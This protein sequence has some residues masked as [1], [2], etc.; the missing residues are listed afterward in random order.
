MPQPSDH[1]GAL[2]EIADSVLRE[3]RFQNFVAQ[4]HSR[5][6]LRQLRTP[7]DQ[8]PAYSAGLDED[9]V[10]A[11][12]TLLYVGL[13]LKLESTP[14]SGDG[15]LTQ[16]AEI[17]EYVY[18]RGADDDPE[19]VSQLFTA[20][21]AYYMAGHF[22]RAFVLVRDLE[23]ESPLPRFLRPLRHLLL[24]QHRLLRR[25]VLDQ[26][27][28]GEY[29]DDGIA[30]AVAAGELDED[31]ALCRILEAT[32]FRALSHYLEYARTG[33]RPL[34]EAAEAFLSGGAEVATDHR[35]AD[36]WWY[37]SCV[38][39]MLRTFDRHSLWS[40]L[41]PY[42][43]QP[44]TADLTRQYVRANLRLPVPLT[45]LWPSQVTAVPRLFAPGL[46]NV[47][48]RMPTSA[49]KTKIAELAILA[50]LAQGFPAADMKCVYVAPF[51]SLA[52]EVEQTLRLALRPLGVRV[53]ELYGGFEFTAADRLL[54]ESTQVLV[55][56]PEKLDAF[57]R[58]TPELAGRLRLVIVD[59]GHI[60]SPPNLRSLHEARGLK[61]EVFLQRLVT[62]CQRSGARIV[63]LSAVMP[64]A[65]QFAEWITGGQDG[66]VT[67]DWRPSRLLLG[68]AVWDGR[69]VD[70]EYTHADRTPL[71]HKCF[72]RG[73]VPSRPPEAVP[74]RGRKHPLPRDDDEAIALAALELARHKLTMV[75]VAQRR[76]TEPLGRT[77]LKCIAARRAIAEHA[78][79]SYGL[80]VAAEHRAAIDRC[81]SLI[82]EHMGEDSNH[83][84]FLG[85][86]FVIHHSGLPQPV[87]IAIERLVRAGAVRLVVATTTL[88]QGVNFPI[89]TV[90]V[91]SLDQGHG[92]PVSAM[93]FWNICG[94]AGRGM[95]ENEG[96]VL[97]FAKQCF[98]EW[99]A[100]KCKS[101]AK[102]ARQPAHW[103]R[104]KWQEWCGEQRAAREAYITQYG[105]YQVQSGLLHLL[106]QV[107]DLWTA[108]HGDLDLAAFCEALAN[109]TLD[110]FAP[111]EAL[112]LDSV[113]S[114]LDGLLIAITE[115][116]EAD[117]ITPDTFQSLLTRSLVHLQLATPADRAFVNE[118]FA[119]RVRYIRG[120]YPD[121]GK[122]LQF[123]Q[124]GLPL[125][126]CEFL[127]A[128]RDEL[129][130]LF[131][132]AADYPTWSVAE[133][134]G[135]ITEIAGYLFRLSELAPSDVPDA[136]GR[137]LELWLSGGTPA[138]ML[139][140]GEV[141]ESGLTQDKLNR[142]VD[143]VFG[144]RLPWGLNAVGCYL[145]Q[146]AESV[147]A[148]WP[149]VCDYYSSFVKYGV[150]EA[151][152]CWLLGLGVGS[153]A[154]ATRVG[155][156]IGDRFS[157]PETML[158]WLRSGGID[159][160][161]AQ[162]LSADDAASLREAV[163]NARAASG[164]ADQTLDVRVRRP[165]DPRITLA[166]GTSLLLEP[167]GEAGS[168]NYR[169]LTLSGAVVDE[170]LLNSTPLAS[171]MTNPEFVIAM[172][173]ASPTGTSP[174]HCHVRIG[175]L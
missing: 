100:G 132:K 45:E 79:E 80:P 108:L 170:F 39:V 64:N 146:Y 114:T 77:I 95:K 57:L 49:G 12:Q 46:P 153:R 87:R 34:L 3:G 121:R 142:W 86:G 32:L 103:R 74:V 60:I 157:N 59:E 47:C 98:E 53:S 161:T 89:H 78:G 134:A 21:L 92:Q 61:Y 156:L 41:A 70:I 90:L 160:L 24:K 17:L 113:L 99:D 116:C 101:S 174:E 40:N 20:A 11:A 55:A 6:V 42:L 110:L 154:V 71:G 29:A 133:R 50:Q 125:R 104:Q 68:E 137:V 38:R 76:S 175:Q 52:V 138:G 172:V 168:H 91:H 69:Q 5:D 167:A 63:F 2:R 120:R 66:L 152:V 93:D 72:V 51:R 67:S 144:F 162:G 165:R 8:W 126:D 131:Q 115:E 141:R 117:E 143:Q 22:A 35:F 13:R 107:K 139:G 18:S 151:V 81:V 129:L 109:H 75:F 111:S 164:R 106:N 84:H 88:A 102:F 130:G 171:L 163:P 31:A 155:G 150:H 27:L 7:Q 123:Y 65:E 105:T 15:Y 19:R 128:S 33:A 16:G 85:E 26:L 94:R 9:L 159:E 83:A 48:V 136:H 119:A 135:H 54:I 43:G 112:D 10:Y 56:T 44:T 149:D 173:V 158:Q 30:A 148:P 118:A 122:R 96:Q 23:G 140:D 73:F 1:I 36:W 97:F 14:E 145:R 127:E 62:R 166:P 169:L 37:Y 25:E 124:L 58:V 28:L 147:G 4:S 82:R